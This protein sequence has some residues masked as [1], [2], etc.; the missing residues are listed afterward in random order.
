[1]QSIMDHTFTVFMTRGAYVVGEPDAQ[2][3]LRAI[4]VGD[5]HVSVEA[6]IFGDGLARQSMKIVTAHVISVV[7]NTNQVEA[8]W[9]RRPLT[10]VRGGL[11]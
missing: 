5:A 2:R 4:D 8:P 1:M 6:D 3:I 11:T 9:E 7:A 10:V